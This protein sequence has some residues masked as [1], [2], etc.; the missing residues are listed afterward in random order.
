MNTK[1][2]VVPKNSNLK[3]CSN[4]FYKALLFD[5]Q[6]IEDASIQHI[7][8]SSFQEFLTFARVLFNSNPNSKISIFFFAPQIEYLAL[9]FLLRM[10]SIISS[11]DLN[12]YYLMHEPRL[13]KGR[14]NFIKVSLIY[15]Y[16]ILFSYL[17]DK[18]LLPS[19]EAVAQAKTFVKE[20]KICKINLTFDSIS[21]ETLKNNLQQLK[22]CWEICKTFSMI[23]TVTSPDKNPW[24][25]L[26]FASTFNHYYPQKAQFIRAGSDRGIQVNYDEELIIRFPG[27]ISNSAKKFLL[28]LS[29]F[30]VVPYS[31]STQ[32]GVV[33][34]ALSYGKLLIINDIPTFSYLKGLSFVFFTDFND[35]SSMSKCIHDLFTMD[36][37]DYE[38]RYWQA[39][40]YFQE[41]H[42][43][44]YLSKTLQ[45]T[46]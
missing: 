1:Y 34:E 33:T 5:N 3:H 36:I 42:S 46:L 29:H 28:G 26:C 31:F 44:A 15:I 16:Q 40:R 11:T 12:I 19:D 41:N 9:L 39:I 45:E 23:A 22:C 37:N 6:P 35:E 21:K 7:D 2:L 18:I 8:K 17:A 13:Q 38:T 14:A 27:Y 4:T 10:L 43:E 32:S 24:G 25:F 30:V 20:Q